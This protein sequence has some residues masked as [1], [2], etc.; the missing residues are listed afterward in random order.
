ML[1]VIK[2]VESIHFKSNSE[3]RIKRFLCRCECGKEKEIDAYHLTR[4]TS[5]IKS[6]GCIN[7]RKKFK[8]KNILHY[9]RLYNIWHKMIRRC[10]NKKEISYHRYGGRGISVCEKWHNFG[11][12][13]NDMIGEYK[14]EFTIERIDVNGNYEPNNCT[15]IP[16]K[17][18]AKN[19]RTTVWYRGKCLKDACKEAGISYAKV[20]VQFRKGE[21]LDTLF[22]IY[23]SCSV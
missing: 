7:K 13:Y 20:R 1:E 14:P 21:D 15:W 17:D 9:R 19:R 3:R 16:S 11:H 23:K 2:E 10:E 6:C 5:A 18:Q 4:K 8:T 12:F 22:K